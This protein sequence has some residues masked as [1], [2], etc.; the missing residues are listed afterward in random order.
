MCAVT[1]EGREFPASISLSPIETE[2]GP[3]VAAAIRDI[4]ERKSAEQ[5]IEFLAYRDALTGLPNRLLVQDRFAQAMAYADRAKTKVALLFL[6][7]DNFKTI[8]DSLGHAVGDALLKE[9]AARLG[10]CVRDT[11]T[12]SRQGGDEFLIVL[13]DLPDADATAPV[14]VKIK[15]RLQDP[16]D[17]DGHELSTSVSIGVALYPDDGGDFDTLLKKADTAMYRAKDAGRNTYRFFEFMCS[18]KKR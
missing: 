12:I 6:D 17:A 13:P 5:Q 15:E 2:Q 14:L 1:K 4:T 16:F 18:S 10:E 3:M 8:N 11:D 7:L 9:I